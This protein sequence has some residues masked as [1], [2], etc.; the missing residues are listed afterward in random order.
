MLR[1]MR[2]EQLVNSGR[3]GTAAPAT[4]LLL[5]LKRPLR[6][7]S[8]VLMVRLVIPHIIGMTDADSGSG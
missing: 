6:A 5:E 2:S 7:P 8:S 3:H 4:L 1:L